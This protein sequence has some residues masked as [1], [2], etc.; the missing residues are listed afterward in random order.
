MTLWDEPFCLIESG[1]K[2]IELRLFDEKRQNLKIG[3]TI[4]FTNLKSQKTLRVLVKNL[5]VFKDF[6]EL[7]NSLDLLKCGYTKADI[8][9]ARAGDMDKYYSKQQQDEYGVVGIEIEKM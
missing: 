8:D 6:K 1:T 4:E 7:Y 5:Y 9:S 2:T 3:D